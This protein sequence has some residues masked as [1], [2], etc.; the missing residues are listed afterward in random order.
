TFALL[1]Q[2]DQSG[3]FVILFFV[4]LALYFRGYGQLRG[5]TYPTVI[6]GAVA[7]AL[8]YPHYFLEVNGYSLSNLITPLIQIIMFGMG[9]SMAL[10]DFIGVVKMPKGVAVGM[11]LQISIM[12][13][14]GFLLAS[15]SNLPA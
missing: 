2:F 12:P 11:F 7:A 15:A 10:S 9:T 8:F 5:Y 14:I 1:G 3:P 6:F 13:V 4:S